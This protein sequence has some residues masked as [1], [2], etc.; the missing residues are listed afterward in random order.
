MAPSIRI[1]DLSCYF[2]VVLLR[3]LLVPSDLVA[4]LSDDIRHPTGGGYE[5]KGSTMRHGQVEKR[6]KKVL[7]VVSQHLIDGVVSSSGS[8]PA[9][10]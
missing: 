4:T 7:G 8:P 10:Q 2:G 5:G 6:E 1:I 3:Q 9:R